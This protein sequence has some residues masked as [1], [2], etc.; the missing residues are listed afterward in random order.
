M[1]ALY[2]CGRQAD[3]LAAF[4]DARQFLVDELGVQP[5]R[6]LRVL[7]ERILAADPE[8]EGRGAERASRAIPAELPMPSRIR[9]A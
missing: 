5:G 1:L 4:R 3:A 9:R 2:R 7:H 8:L 6:E